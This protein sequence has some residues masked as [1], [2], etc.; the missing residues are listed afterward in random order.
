MAER[1][2]AS[3]RESHVQPERSAMLLAQLRAAEAARHQAEARGGVERGLLRKGL[4]EELHERLAHAEREAQVVL[5]HHVYEKQQM[6]A[7]HQKALQAAAP[8]Q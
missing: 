2:A 5:L 6:D 3:P 1:P 7:T 8:R 4:E